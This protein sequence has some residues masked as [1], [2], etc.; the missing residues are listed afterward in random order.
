MFF[1]VKDKE[2]KLEKNNKEKNIP[3]LKDVIPEDLLKSLL[4][5]QR[6]GVR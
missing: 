1:K 6:D 2:N 4:P 5:F 3:L